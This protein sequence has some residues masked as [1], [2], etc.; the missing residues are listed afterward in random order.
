MLRSLFRCSALALATGF[1]PLSGPARKLQT[2]CCLLPI[3][4]WLPISSRATFLSLSLSF[5]VTIFVVAGPVQAQEQLF[6]PDGLAGDSFGSSVVISDSGDLAIV[7]A[8]YDD[9]PGGGSAY[10]FTLEPDGS[11]T[12]QQQLLASDGGRPDNTRHRD[13]FGSSIAISSSGD[14]VIIG[15]VE[16]EDGN[17]WAGG[18]AYIFTRATDGIWSEQEMWWGSG[19]DDPQ[20]GTSVALSASGDVALVGVPQLNPYYPG[21]AAALYNRDINGIWTHKGNLSGTQGW[22]GAEEV[23][24][25][26]HSVALSAAGDLA[27]VGAPNCCSGE[28]PPEVIFGDSGVVYSFGTVYQSIKAPDWGPRDDFGWSVAISDT[29]DTAI[30]GARRKDTVGGIDAGSAY[31]LNRDP[32][33][34]WIFGQQLF[35]PDG[36]AGDQFGNVVSLSSSGD[37]ALV[38]SALD[39]TSGGGAEAGSAYVFTRDL[40]GIW[41]YSEKLLAPDSSANDHFGSSIALSPT[42]DTAIIGAEN[43]DTL[44]GLDAGSAYVLPLPDTDTDG[45]PDY[46]DNCIDVQNPNQTD[47]DSDGLGDACNDAEDSD[48]GTSGPM[49]S[50]TVPSRRTWTKPIQT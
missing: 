32:S 22:A 38:S 12:M 8:E 4:G 33:G 24:L 50:T 28:S 9:T 44:G 13:R 27:L 46:L 14:T 42:G 20:F 7:G 6:A 26:G 16:R 30:V 15:A 3:S 29:G 48:M 34:T 19:S 17:G 25:F 40:G 1:A 10:V 49:R 5:A 45:I 23:Q 2:L 36:S 31:I 35:A 18:A 43:D 41:N 21:G 39:T 37:L 11:W 47:T